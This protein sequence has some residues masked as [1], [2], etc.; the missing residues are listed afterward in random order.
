MGKLQTFLALFLLLS[1]TYGEKISGTVNVADSD[2]FAFL[3][4]F[5]FQ[6]LSSSNYSVKYSPAAGTVDVELSNKGDIGS[7]TYKLVMYDD[8]ENSWTKI[9][10]TGLTCQEKVEGNYKRLEQSV[11]LEKDETYDRTIKIHQHIRPRWW[12]L[13]LANCDAMNSVNG[14]KTLTDIDY[15]LHFK[16]NVTAWLNVEVGSNDQGLNVMYSVYLAVYV[17]LFGLQLYAYYVYTIQQYIHQVIKLLTAA[18]ALQMFAVLFHFANWIIFTETG[19]HEIFFPIIASLCEIMAST[20]FLLLLMV[21]AQGWTVSR[22]EVVYPKLLLSS[23]VTIAVIQCVL[24]IWILIGLD[25][26]TTTYVYNTVPQYIYGSVFVVIGII[27]V[28]QCLFS[29]KN[30]PLDSKKNLYILLAAFFSIWFLWPLLRILIGD[31]FKPWNRDVFVQTISMTLTTLTYFAMMMLMW[32][33]WAHQY[34]NLSMVDTQERILDAGQSDMM[35]QSV[36]NNKTNYK[37]LEQDR[38]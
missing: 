29:Y 6:D 3:G 30:E 8:Q 26:Q 5:C 16:Q 1:A 17:I 32:P 31:G 7:D 24:Y 2:G 11:E 15:V 36:N 20:V 35:A 37:V 4:K 12:W 18:I 25:D 33:T 34:F 38:L 23:V 10:D 14:T 27:F 28:A 9:Y 19:E 13:Y 22:F 21:L